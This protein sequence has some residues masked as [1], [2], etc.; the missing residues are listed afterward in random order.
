MGEAAAAVHARDAVPCIGCGL[1]LIREVDRVLGLTAEAAKALSDPRQRGKVK[2]ELQRML[3][4]RVYG[5][6]A[7]YEDLND[8]ETLRDDT[9][10]QMI[11]ES[12]SRLAGKSTLCRLENEQGRE[13]AEAIHRLLVEQFIASPGGRSRRDCFGLRR[14]G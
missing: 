5:L 13:V 14:H 9:L 3:K 2:H 7:G 10:F 11:S 6:C 8:F 4:Q 12:D 1:L